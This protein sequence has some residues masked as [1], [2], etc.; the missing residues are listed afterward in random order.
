MDKVLVANRGEIACRIFRSC[1]T[2]G[3]QTVA[4]HSAA[5]AE[6]LHVELADE[7]VDIGPAP[8]RESYLAADRIIDAALHSGAHA[9]HPGYGFLAESAGFADKVRD[10]GLIWVG[11]DGKTIEDM[12]DKER[13]R[14]IASAS[15]VPVLPG[16][17]R[18]GEG[19]LK[20]IE[21]AAEEVGFPLLVKASAGGGGIGMRKLESM[22]GLR[23]AA[24]ATQAMAG[25]AFGDGTIYLE[26]FIPRARHVE[27]QIF[28]FGDGSAVHLRERDCSMQRRFQKI[29]EESP[30]PGIPDDVREEMAEAATRLARQIK[31]SGAGTIEFIVDA[32]SFEFFFLE[33]NT[34]IQV[35]HPVTEMLTARDLVSMQLEL[36]RGTL[37]SL[38]QDEISSNGHSIECRIYAERPEKHFMPSPGRLEIFRL[39]GSSAS[40]RIDTGFR[41]GDTVTPFYDPMIAKVIVWGDTREA[42]LD[43]MRQALDQIRIEG[44]GSNVA[45]LKKV[46]GHESFRRG[47]VYTALIQDHLPSLV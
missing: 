5:D 27:V 28:G 2:L 39:P 30:A 22:D 9:I 4:V 25:K 35:E 46:I 34:R 44:L 31:Y 6:A 15:G 47:D 38:D 23:E 7:S 26:R 8:A 43:N 16:S 11:P 1:R 13:A 10:A 3:L 40:V 24:E 21:Q 20:G 42:A 14:K 32:D 18:F 17:R 37:E 12:G 36:A 19:D 29:I 45:F 33:M 41:S